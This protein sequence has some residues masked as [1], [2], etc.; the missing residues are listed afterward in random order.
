MLQC[1]QRR[2][3]EILP[4]KCLLAASVINKPTLPASQVLSTH[5]EL[6]TLLPAHW[7]V[8]L[9]PVCVSSTLSIFP[10][11]VK[12]VGLPFFVRLLSAVWFPMTLFY[13]IHPQKEN[14]LS[15]MWEG[16]NLPPG[17]VRGL[18]FSF[19]PYYV[20]NK[21]SHRMEDTGS[22]WSLPSFS[23]HW[24]LQTHLICT[25]AAQKALLSC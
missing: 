6:R 22:R 25:L 20:P 11:W 15:R 12:N 16:A 18:S 9:E 10:F 4:K 23:E 13:F 2:G 8:P 14:R 24:G 19:S 7:T 17:W 1:G 5:R 3:L 21:A